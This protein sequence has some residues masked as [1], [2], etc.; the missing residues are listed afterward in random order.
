MSASKQLLVTNR[1]EGGLFLKVPPICDS[2]VGVYPSSDCGL[3]LIMV[4]NS[5]CKNSGTPLFVWTSNF[6]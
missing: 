3:L 1:R 5:R 4:N 2:V 6:C